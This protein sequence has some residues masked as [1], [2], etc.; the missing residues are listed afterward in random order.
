M[1]S[2]FCA[3]YPFDFIVCYFEAVILLVTS[4]AHVDSSHSKENKISN[5]QYYFS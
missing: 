2:V 5:L 1:L 3:S 4:V